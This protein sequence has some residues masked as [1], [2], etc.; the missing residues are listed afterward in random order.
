[1]AP[2][3]RRGGRPALLLA[4]TVELLLAGWWRWPWTVAPIETGFDYGSGHVVVV[5]EN[6]ARAGALRQHFLPVMSTDRELPE[7]PFRTEFSQEYFSVP[8]L[9]F[10]L[11]YAATRAFP[12]IEPV[13]LAK[14]V[15]QTLIC[16]S[17]LVA[18]SL[19]AVAFDA[20][21]IFVGLSF[22]ISGVPF[23]L[24]FANGYFAL[25]VGL[26]V[27]LVLVAWCAAVAARSLDAAD[28]AAAPGSGYVLLG[29]IL[30]FLGAF[31]DYIPLAANG[32]AFAGLML[33]A[34]GPQVHPSSRR[35]AR[36]SAIGIAIG[37]L[38]AVSTTVVLYSRQM[39][40]AR[41]RRALAQRVADRSGDAPFLERVDVIRR[42]MLTAWPRALLVVL[43]GVFVAVLIWCIV[44]AVRRRSA[45][46]SRRAVVILYALSVSVIP[47]LGFHYRA[48]NYVRFHWWFAGTW[49]I[50]FAIALCGLVELVRRRD[51]SI[52][53]GLFSAS[54]LAWIVVANA[55]FTA[56]QAVVEP[57][58]SDAVR[59]YRDVG[60]EL[61]HD[62]LPLVVTDV[63]A[64]WPGL[65]E[66]FPYA[67]A[68]LRRPVLF[69]EPTGAI[70]LPKLNDVYEG[71]P[72]QM[73]GEDMSDALRRRE[74]DVY[75]AYDPEAREC[76]GADVRAARSAGAISIAV[77][78]APARMLVENPSAVLGPLRPGYACS[79]PPLAPHDLRVTSNQGGRVGIAW[80]RSAT[81]R[82]SYIL[83]VGRARGGAEALVSNLG[84]ATTFTAFPVLPGTYFVRIRGRNACGTGDPSNELAVVVSES[85]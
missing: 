71:R 19:F 37:S 4:L 61:P 18:A 79:A 67:T 74:S 80:S 46:D 5:S 21:S 13:L 72:F 22:L 40:L 30:A 45:A 55:R 3:I 36:R 50:G 73:G 11:H 42:Q 82:A 66:D 59:M 58:R 6:W 62:G 29:G 76:R 25:N 10:M 33:L 83:E 41:Y 81:R 49:T 17:V 16:A 54:L 2:S 26:A 12:R 64:D 14:L 69:R 60:R 38:A 78:R 39:G 68:Y 44:S 77:C 51:A 32:T 52:R 24:W 27:Q 35:F 85:N 65:F 75:V 43:G 8:P 57:V 70:R 7:W 20:W 34:I 47:S 28:T 15:A 9:A 63:T 56:A 53:A 48:V 31:A 84:R 1:M 23:L